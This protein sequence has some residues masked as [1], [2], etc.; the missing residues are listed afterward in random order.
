MK[1]TVGTCAVA[2]ILSAG[3]TLAEEIDLTITGVGSSQGS[4][5]IVI[6]A[7]EDGYA[8]R[9][10]VS[11]VVEVPITGQ[12]AHWRGEMPDGRYAI[13]AHHDRNGDS[14]LNR[15]VFGLP[16]EAYGY[17]NAAWTSFGLPSFEAVAFDVGEQV[18]VQTVPLRF[19]GFVSTL[20]IGVMALAGLMVV[21]AAR[22]VARRCL[23]PAE[24]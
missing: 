8:G 3:A 24:V 23:A 17:S 6:M 18:A 15:P 19:N 16:L 2:L 12:Q 11:R 4:A 7:G 10:P 9:V 5:R 1:Q 22:V 20:Q 21:L 13:I 14:A